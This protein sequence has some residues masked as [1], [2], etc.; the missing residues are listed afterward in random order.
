MREVAESELYAWLRLGSRRQ[1][2][3]IALHQPMTA[4]QLSRVLEY[5]AKSC[6]E[7]L[8]ELANRGLVRCLNPRAN[9]SRL[10]WLTELGK[11][12]Q[13]QLS[14]QQGLPPAR[15]DFPIVD[16]DLYGWTLHAHRSQVIKVME[17]PMQPAGIKR[18]A[19]YVNPAIRMSANNVRD[20]IK[21]LLER[22]IVEIVP[23]KRGWK[24][25]A[26]TG[27]GKALRELLYRASA[28]NP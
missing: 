21:L 4:T 10:Y 15:H 19:R 8:C 16:W 26:L 12:L 5:D 27:Q 9:R 20:V 23:R 17:G 22:G 6:G 28:K 13:G 24:R 25:Y 7:G 3:L 2:I 11:D 14:A 18:R 1:R